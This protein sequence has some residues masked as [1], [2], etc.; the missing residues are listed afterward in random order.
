MAGSLGARAMTLVDALVES[1]T[2]GRRRSD[3][4]EFSEMVG[5]AVDSATILGR[6][7]GRLRR[8]RKKLL[9]D[10]LCIGRV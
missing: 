4:A 10:L 5:E 2:F 8:G 1:Y 3:V 7:R 6:H 9:H